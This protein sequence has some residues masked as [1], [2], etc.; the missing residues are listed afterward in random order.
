MSRSWSKW[1]FCALVLGAVSGCSSSNDPATGS[2]HQPSTDA[3]LPA[4]CK[5]ATIYSAGIVAK[6]DKG[7]I[8]VT[9]QD[10]NPAP[11]GVGDNDW[12]IDVKD[13]DGN[14]LAG[15]KVEFLLWMPAHGHP[16]AKNPIIT[17]NGDG[18]YDAKGVYF[19]M[20]GLWQITV[21]VTSSDGSIADSAM[22]TLCAQ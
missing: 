22:F 3:G 17:D 18:T 21:K 7:L 8:D 19:N 14:S 10:S 6:G 16:G 11:P 9:L 20:D 5:G 12:T 2:G 1:C 13:K 4:K 15:A